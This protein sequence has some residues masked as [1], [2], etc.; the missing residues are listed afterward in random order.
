LVKDFPFGTGALIRFVDGETCYNDEKL[1]IT[2][3]GE[4]VIQIV[5]DIQFPTRISEKMS[6][7]LNSIG[8][9]GDNNYYN[10]K[11]FP[12]IAGYTTNLDISVKRYGF[13]Y[14]FDL[15]LFQEKHLVSAGATLDDTVQRAK[16]QK[17]LNA[18]DTKL[19]KLCVDHDH[20]TGYVR[21][22]LCHGCNTGI[23]LLK[24]KEEI[25]L[26]AIEYLRKFKTTLDG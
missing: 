26:K 5:V 10:H 2:V 11:V 18:D 17:W 3:K 1:W 24:E 23:G 12:V 20:Q 21:S 9:I 7:V 16:L 8:R 25:L 13:Q 4:E 19:K 15:P 14:W 22:L 6:F